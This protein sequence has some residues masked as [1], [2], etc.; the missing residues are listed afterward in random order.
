[1]K[2][3]A[4]KQQVCQLTGTVNTKQLKQQRPDLVQNRDLRRRDHWLE[5]LDQLRV[6]ND[7]S[8][9]DL[10]AS[11]AMLKAS[12]FN[13]DSLC[14]VAVEDTEIAWTRIQLESQF[15]DIHIEQL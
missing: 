2:L 7:I 9:A 10:E 11:E 6:I 12:L 14:G 5:I 8:L 4:I 13:V 3:T 1:M 15:S